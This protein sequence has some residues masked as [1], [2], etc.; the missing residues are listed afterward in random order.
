MPVRNVLQ[1]IAQVNG[2]N[3]VT[4]DTVRGNVTVSLSGVPR[5]QSLDMILKIRG[6]DKRLEGNILLIAPQKNSLLAR[7]NNYKIANKSHS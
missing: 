5:D 3:L 6:L 1:I 7:H 4:T 2:F